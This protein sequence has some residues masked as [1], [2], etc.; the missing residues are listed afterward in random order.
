[1]PN[2]LSAARILDTA[3]ILAERRGWECLRLGDVATELG[4]ALD[5]IARHYRDKDALVEAWFDRADA[6]LLTRSKGADLP[7]LELLGRL[8][9]LLVA[10]LKALEP[11]REVTEQMLCY[12]LEPGHLHLQL[13]GLQRISRT[14]Q[15]WREAAGCESSHCWRVGEE[16]ALTLVYLRAFAHWLRHPEESEIQFRAFLRRRLR[17]W[18]PVWLRRPQ[19]CPAVR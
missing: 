1:M 11:H 10:W 12:K 9:E 17:C 15:W 18:L 2:T 13:G 3:L 7:A 8:E 5:D 16:C 14:V 6:A 19:A 4:V